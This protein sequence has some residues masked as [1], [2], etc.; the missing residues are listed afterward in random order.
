[1]SFFSSDNWSPLWLTARLCILCQ[2][3]RWASILMSAISDIRHRH[4]LFRYWKKICRSENCHSYI[5]KIPSRHP[6]PFRYPISKKDPNPRPLS[7]QRALYY[8][9]TV[10]NYKILDVGNRISDKS[11]FRYRYN[12]GLRSLQSNIGSSGIK[13]IPISLITDIGVL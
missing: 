2:L 4:L 9:A 3:H 11:L 8:S 12:V 13:L 6:S 1:M 10:L 5:G 7:L